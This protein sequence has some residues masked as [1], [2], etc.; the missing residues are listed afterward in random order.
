MIAETNLLRHFIDP[1]YTWLPM[2]D[3]VFLEHTLFIIPLLPL[4]GFLFNGLFGTH[5]DKKVSGWIAVFAA[6][7]SFLW[8]LMSVNALGT[9]TDVVETRNV[10]H[11]VYGTWLKTADFSFSFGLILDQ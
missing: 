10:L 7:G 2:K 3:P 9:L 6:L 4:L 8:A 11:S 1:I 5:V